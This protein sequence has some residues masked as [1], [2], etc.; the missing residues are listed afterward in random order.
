M[1]PDEQVEDVLTETFV[2]AWQAVATLDPAQ[3]ELWLKTI[4]RTCV[5]ARM[6]NAEG[7]ASGRALPVDAGPQAGG[8]KEEARRLSCAEERQLL[9]FCPAVNS[10]SADEK[11][12]VGLACFRGCNQQEIA[13][14]SGLPL[15]TVKSMMLRAQE[16][17]RAGLADAL[18]AGAAA[19]S[20]SSSA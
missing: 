3:P 10:L 19:Q 9:A 1:V 11:N 12:V 13:C 16:K 20:R 15:A 4:A 6:R 5:L 7:D 14:I 2:Q 18:L 17:L 8:V